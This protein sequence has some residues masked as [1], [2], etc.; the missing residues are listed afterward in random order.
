M[1]I[2][3]LIFIIS[4]FIPAAV[5]AITM[6]FDD[7]DVN[8]DGILSAEEAAIVRGLEL[9]SAD[10]NRDGELS[11]KEYETATAR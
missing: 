11:R 10:T 8:E 1:R 4:F 9:E 3:S 6:T 5:S 7:L 2:T